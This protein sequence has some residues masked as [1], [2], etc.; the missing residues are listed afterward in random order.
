M[1]LLHIDT[2]ILG[3]RSV[4]RE[5]TGA[6]VGKLKTASTDIEVVYRDLALAPPAHMTLASLPGDHPQSAWAGPL[7]D[8]GQAVRNESQ[9]IL[10]E[11]MA[12]D[13][14]VVG[15]PMYNFGIPSQLKAWIDNVVVPGKTFRYGAHGH[16]GLVGSK[17]VIV[18]IARGGI[19][20]PQTAA[21]D[22]EHAE[23]YMRT[24]L[25]FIGVTPEFV[26]AEGVAGGEEN[27]TNALAAALD[28][29]EQLVP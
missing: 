19:Y 1:K 8:V 9:Q 18:A 13:V 22:A 14:V 2:S 12:A 5:I 6:I 10:D 21:I 29:V 23:S 16:E 25:L 7:D 11:F 24:V 26:V 3:H 17:R 27:R 20:A 4:S 15:V 28:A